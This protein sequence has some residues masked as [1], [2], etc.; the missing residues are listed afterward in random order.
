MQRIDKFVSSQTS[1]SRNDVKKLLKKGLI[2]VNGNT[3]SKSNCLVDENN[4][5]ITVNG[6]EINYK[7]YVYLV[8]NKPKGYVSAT[9]DSSCATVIDLC[10]P[11]FLNRNLFPVGRLDKDTTGLM[12]ISDDG[13][14]AHNILAPKKHVSKKYYVELSGDLSDEMVEDFRNGISL[15]DGECKSSI[16]EIIDK[17]SCYV[18]LTEGRYHQIKRMFGCY[19]LDVLEL[20]RIRIGNLDLPSDLEIG[21]SR[22]LTEDELKKITE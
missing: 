11:D 10:P 2:K 14:F 5:V 6:E 21:E 13:D 17:R 9:N 12:I 19:G 4:D 15:N 20:K 7:K 8:L 1:L 18:T 16:L 22:E 3:I